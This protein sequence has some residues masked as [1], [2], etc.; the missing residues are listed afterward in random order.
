MSSSERAAL[1]RLRALADRETAA[2][3]QDILRALQQLQG[4]VPLDRLER[5]LAMRDAFALH[6]LAASLPARLRPALDRLQG[7]FLQAGQVSKWLLPAVAQVKVRF[8]ATNPFA[9]AAARE[10]AA[11]LV[12]QVTAE[13]RQAIRTLVARAFAEGIPPRE[14]ARLLRPLIG[15]TE[16]QAVAA[17]GRFQ[18]AIARGWSRAAAE[19]AAS[20][21]A[22]QLLRQRAVL[23]ARTEVISA[24]TRGMEAAW[25]EAARKGLLSQSARKV[26]MTTPDDK[27]C[28][29]CRAMH[30]ESVPLFAAF[31][32]TVGHFGFVNGPPLHPACRCAL[33]IDPG[34]PMGVAA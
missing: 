6:D 16:R 27:L 14:L 8:D 15:L 33:R 11:A 20:S 4:V 10:W 25:R 19:R 30:N 7:T 31:R 1:Q 5:V 23:I 9:Y 2:V 13:T 12:T 26:W 22:G 28:P 18:D 17:F 34:R 29:Y 3:A 21:Y 24:S 32:P